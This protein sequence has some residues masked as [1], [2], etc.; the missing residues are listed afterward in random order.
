[1][2]TGQPQ[3]ARLL[4][5]SRSGPENLLCTSLRFAWQFSGL[6][7]HGLA[8]K[9]SLKLRTSCFKFLHCC[10]CDLT[11]GAVCPSRSGFLLPARQPRSARQ[12]SRRRPLSCRCAASKLL[13][14][15]AAP[16]PC[17]GTLPA[18]SAVRRAAHK[19]APYLGASP[20][21]QSERRA[22][23]EAA[24]Q[25][26]ENGATPAGLSGPKPT[27]KID[28]QR[29]P[30]A[31]VVSIEYGDKLGELLDTVRAGSGTCTLTTLAWSVRPCL[32]GRRV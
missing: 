7:S 20:I 17:R 22:A 13:L 31:T 2:H 23:S 21:G 1:M 10:V 18:C 30:F 5:G 19:H 32:P 4:R 16:R 28:N 12:S 11:G 3:V 27:V 9:H 24:V 14:P 25:T 15:A 26:T 29:D 8:H 6:T